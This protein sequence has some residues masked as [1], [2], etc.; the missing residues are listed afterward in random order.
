MNVSRS[1]F[2]SLSLLCVCNS[3]SLLPE[4]AGSIHASSANTQ[5][6]AAGVTVLLCAVLG[7]KRLVASNRYFVAKKSFNEEGISRGTAASWT[8]A[9]CVVGGA[10]SVCALG[11]VV[12]HYRNKLREAE[13]NLELARKCCTSGT[14][15]ATIQQVAGKIGEM[16]TTMERAVQGV[17]DT[18]I[19]DLEKHSA[20]VTCQALSYASE[21]AKVAGENAQAGLVTLYEQLTS[22]ATSEAASVYYQ[23]ACVQLATASGG[24]G[25]LAENAK[26]VIRQRILEP[27]R[28][29]WK[30]DGQQVTAAQIEEV[31]SK[32]P[33]EEAAES[34][35]EISAA[36]AATPKER[37]QDQSRAAC[38][39]RIAHQ[40]VNEFRSSWKRSS[41]QR[42]ECIRWISGRMNNSEIQ[43][44]NSQRVELQG[45]IAE[46]GSLW[47]LPV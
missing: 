1:L 45:L 21:I 38:V 35:I 9:V 42:Q 44:T 14:V 36:P 46:L 34:W 11:Y 47:V 17:R 5:A 15:E 18:T 27:L 24:A 10:L 32:W 40:T 22:E 12:N 26:Q 8:P 7:L 23:A 29:K 31:L 37:C 20:E 30:S 6:I 16:R 4:L 43:L 3:S 28:A 33:E 25:E 2:V 41:S 13:K 19:G 39:M